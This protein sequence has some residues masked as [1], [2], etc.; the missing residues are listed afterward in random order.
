[1]TDFKAVQDLLGCRNYA[2]A[3][4]TFTS[5]CFSEQFIPAYLAHAIFNTYTC[6]G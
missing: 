5:G 2:E 1:M 3:C 6:E 4:F